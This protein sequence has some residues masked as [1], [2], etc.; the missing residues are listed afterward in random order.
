MGERVFTKAQYGIESTSGTAVAATKIW[1]GTVTVPPDRTVQFLRPLTGRR[2]GPIV[3]S[4]PQ[5]LIDGLTMAMPEAIYLE[6]LPV[7]LAMLLDGTVSYVSSP[8]SWTFTPGLTAA[9]TVKSL[10]L[11]WGDDTQAY[12]AEYVT[13]KSLKIRGRTGENGYCTSELTCFAKQITKTTFTASLTSGTLTPLISN[14]AV[15]SIDTAWAGL[16]GTAKSGLLR[17]WDIEINN[18]F[19]PKHLASGALTFGAVGIGELQGHI[20]RLE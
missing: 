1:P 15:L 9:P 8:T 5:V 12:E 19:H 3:S 20:D 13:A 14:L 7:Q 10:T 6:A 16:G 18:G 11:E 17:E 2:G 4:V